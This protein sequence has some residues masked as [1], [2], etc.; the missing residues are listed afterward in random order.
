M[1]W[2]NYEPRSERRQ[3]ETRGTERK[4]LSTAKA[5]P[6]IRDRKEAT[7]TTNMRHRQ[8]TTSTLPTKP[9]KRGNTN[10]RRFK[11]MPPKEFAT[12]AKL[13]FS[14]A[15]PSLIFYGPPPSFARFCDP[16]ISSQRTSHTLETGQQGWR[17]DESTHLPPMRPGFKSQRRRYIWVEFVVGSLLC[18]ERFVSG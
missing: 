14:F 18:S 10:C 6:S 15:L 12:K 1:S 17:S 2:L 4:S 8:N 3:Q 7:A 16:S 9:M 13:H 11:K 5:T